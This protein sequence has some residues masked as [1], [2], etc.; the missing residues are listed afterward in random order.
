MDLN[1][2]Q[3]GSAGQL[4]VYQGG[5]NTGTNYGANSP[6]VQEQ[7]GGYGSQSNYTMGDD[8]S[9]RRR[10]RRNKENEPSLVSSAAPLAAIAGTAAAAFG[11]GSAMSSV[12]NVVNNVAGSGG[13]FLGKAAKTATGGLEDLTI[14]AKDAGGGILGTLGKAAGSVG[15]GLGS[16]WDAIEPSGGFLGDVPENAGKGLGAVGKGLG[17]AWDAIEPSGGFLGDIG[18]G[19]KDF[20]ANALGRKELPSEEKW[21]SDLDSANRS[22]RIDPETGKPQGE[23]DNPGSWYNTP[24]GGWFKGSEQE[25]NSRQKQLESEDKAGK[26]GDWMKP[27]EGGNW[28]SDQFKDFFK[29]GAPFAVPAPAAPSIPVPGLP[30]PIPVP[31][32]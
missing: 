27:G 16:A 11:L 8:N 12:G 14:A 13:D 24:D 4:P 21:K 5:I 1:P 20:A 6:Y 23:I 9:N 31:V 22:S 18:G 25:Y 17:S 3:F 10:R 28:F 30:A 2:N 32:P 19:I 26:P 15:K 29:G 7:A